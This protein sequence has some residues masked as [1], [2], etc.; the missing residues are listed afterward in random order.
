LGVFCS[1]RP[2][3]Q[4]LE[5]IPRPTQLGYSV[6]KRLFQKHVMKAFL[7]VALLTSI[8]VSEKAKA[9]DALL[10]K[11][12]DNYVQGL[13]QGNLSVL[14]AAFWPEGQF[15]AQ[16]TDTVVC[17]TFAHVLPGWVT[18][19]DPAAKGVIRSQETNGPMARVTYE[20]RF[21]GRKFLDFLLLY[22]TGNRW[23]IV[24]KTTRILP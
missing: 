19:P 24:A 23:V 14:Q 12:L 21:G 10:K 3:K 17:Q 15:C 8:G 18:K 4:K 1:K 9:Q 5:Q 13:R 2:L 22:K 7:M 16:Q 20:L 6:Q 11:A